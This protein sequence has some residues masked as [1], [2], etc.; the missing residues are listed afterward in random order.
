MKGFAAI[1]GVI[2]LTAVALVIVPGLLSLNS[3][4]SSIAFL[5]RLD[6]IVL[7]QT[8]QIDRDL[9]PSQDNAFDI[10]SAELRWQDLFVVGGSI[11]L[12][13]TTLEEDDGRFTSSSPISLKDGLHL[14]GEDVAGDFHIFI[15]GLHQN[16]VE[17]PAAFDNSLIFETHSI[18]NLYAME[19]VFWDEQTG[20]PSLV[21]NEGA[22]GRAT[23]IERSLI[24]GAQK[25]TKALDGNYTLGT[26]TFANLAFDTS[27]FGAD[28]GVEHDIE[29]LGTLFVDVIDASSGGRLTF[30]VPITVPAIRVTNGAV[31]GYIL[32]GDAQGNATWTDPQELQ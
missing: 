10:G 21:L 7:G 22:A 26:G 20:R 18:Q 23:V 19:V 32:I 8:S 25:G 11:H 17:I 14:V 16:E 4:P 5:E 9:I 30:A 28:L 1:I 29:L 31:E 27:V 24:L 6:Y 3:V 13:D 12:G 2:L 15:A